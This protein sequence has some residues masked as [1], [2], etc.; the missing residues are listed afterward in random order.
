MWHNQEGTEPIHSFS[1]RNP[2]VT[3][4]CGCDIDHTESLI[5]AAQEKQLQISKVDYR[6]GAVIQDFHMTDTVSVSLASLLLS[7][8]VL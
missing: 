7:C 6:G 5:A 2:H 1:F 8:F 3:S 4:I